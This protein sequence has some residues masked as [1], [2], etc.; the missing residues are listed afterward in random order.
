[1]HPL[2]K[3]IPILYW[4][5]LRGIFDVEILPIFIENDVMRNGLVFLSIGIIIS[6]KS[7]PGYYEHLHR[8]ARVMCDAGDFAYNNI[9][10]HVGNTSIIILG[11]YSDGYVS[12]SSMDA[13]MIVP[14]SHIIH[15]GNNISIRTA[16]HEV[17]YTELP[18]LVQS[19]LGRMGLPKCPIFYGTQSH[20]VYNPTADPKDADLQGIIAEQNETISTYKRLMSDRTNAY[21]SEQT[22]TNFINASK[23][24][25]KK[26]TS[27]VLR[28]GN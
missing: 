20:I 5:V 4:W 1:M 24:K 7:A 23:D 16:T 11:G 13:V 19:E 25:L 6:P 14:T 10:H 21:D 28:V 15:L 18:L 2:I 22:S 8:S 12:E 9:I 17:D 27:E 3:F 26:V